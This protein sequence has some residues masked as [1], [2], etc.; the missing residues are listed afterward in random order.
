M[1]A[2]CL[3]TALAILGAAWVVNGVV[4]LRARGEL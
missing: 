3:A 1:N 4:R 2:R